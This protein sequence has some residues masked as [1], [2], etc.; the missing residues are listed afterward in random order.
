VVI[1]LIIAAVVGIYYYQ[2][3]QHSYYSVG[4]YLYD[5]ELFNYIVGPQGGGLRMPPVINMPSFFYVHISPILL[6]FSTISAVLGLRDMQPLQMVL[7]LGFSGAAVAA[8]LVVQYYLRP[9][10]AIVSLALGAVFALA[11]ALGGTMRSTADYPHIEILYVAP[12]AISLLLIFHRHLRW[13]WVAFVT[14]LFVREDAGL[15]MACILGAY[16]ALAAIAERGVPARTKDIAPFLLAA[17]AYPVIVLLAQ[18]AFLPIE[19]NFARIYS[20]KPAYAHLTADLLAHRFDTL[21]TKQPHALL[22]LAASV[23]PFLARPRWIALTGIVA[24]IPWFVASV[25]AVSETAGSLSLYY[26]FPFLVLP[27]VPYVVTAKL[28]SAEAV[29][30]EL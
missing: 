23:I 24:A 9:L 3:F 15:H 25:P 13:A 20:G 22:L 6:P 19:S 5:T 16:L 12:A 7:I 27:L 10:G 14:T 21:L 8:F 29:Y 4:P 30:V 17:L 1:S 11:F 28:P 2:I 18:N 26:A